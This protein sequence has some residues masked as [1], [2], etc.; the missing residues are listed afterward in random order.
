MRLVGDSHGNERGATLVEFAI[1]VPLLFLLLFGIVE[2]ARMVT[3]FTTLRTAAREG[4]RFATTVDDSDG[5]V[6]NYADC[7]GIIAAAEAK[8]V[9]GELSTIQVRW[10]P[11]TGGPITCSNGSVTNPDPEDIV[12]G[13][14]IT[15]KVEG[16]F[17]SVIPLIGAFFDNMRLDSE[18]TR[19]VF[20]GVI[21]EDET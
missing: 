2:S 16:E 19:Q 3:E 13:T 20:K 4:A 17:N 21:N 11:P 14:F 7:A 9:V 1:V 10:D 15:V 5:G 12:A 6:P 18:Q 8:A